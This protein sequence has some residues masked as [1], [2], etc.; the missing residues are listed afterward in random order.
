MNIK[1][2]IET[3][4]NSEKEYPPL[5]SKLNKKEKNNKEKEN[6]YKVN[7]KITENKESN[8]KLPNT[9]WVNTILPIL[10]S[11]KAEK[12]PEKEYESIANKE[13]QSFVPIAT[14]EEMA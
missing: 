10:A 6:D 2:K 13:N 3:N 1:A 4:I 12:T 7:Q 8:N 11:N 5:A 9:C 14:S